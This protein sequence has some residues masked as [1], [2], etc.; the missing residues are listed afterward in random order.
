MWRLV[1]NV[2]ALTVDAGERAF[3]EAR[4]KTKFDAEWPAIRDQLHGIA[5]AAPAPAASTKSHEMGVLAVILEGVRSLQHQMAE[6]TA[7][8][9]SPGA[10]ALGQVMGYP[11]DMGPRS[12]TSLEG[13]LFGPISPVPAAQNIVVTPYVVPGDP[14]DPRRA[15]LE[16]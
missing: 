2:R 16:T 12:P 5:P 10:Q 13:T 15:H 9:S 1:R 6:A 4:L 11:P 7:K 8:R 14:R 3:D